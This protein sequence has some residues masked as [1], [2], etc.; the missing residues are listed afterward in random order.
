[1]DNQQFGGLRVAVCDCMKSRL[2][3]IARSQKG[4]DDQSRI[5]VRIEVIRQDA[6]RPS[7]STSPRECFGNVWSGSECCRFDLATPATLCCGQDGWSLRRP[8]VGYCERFNQKVGPPF[9]RLL[10][11]HAHNCPRNMLADEPRV[12]KPCNCPIFCRNYSSE[13][14]SSEAPLLP[15]DTGQR[16]RLIMMVLIR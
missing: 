4:P 1:M 8:N 9:P 5:Y 10:R 2:T 3:R 16:P 6:L 14:D 12:L 15:G 11:K 13:G 7:D